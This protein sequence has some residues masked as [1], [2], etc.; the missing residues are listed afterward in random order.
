MLIRDELRATFVITNAIIKISGVPHII[1]E[2]RAVTVTYQTA[3]S[4]SGVACAI[5]VLVYVCW[6]GTM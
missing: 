4:F 2:I 6:H 3:F 5:V 1:L